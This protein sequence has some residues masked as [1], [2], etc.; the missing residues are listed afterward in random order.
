MR[1]VLDTNIIISG[2]FWHG[3]SNRVLESWVHKDF[4][5]VTS[6]ELL[7]ETRRILTGFKLRLP[8]SLIDI[9]IDVLRFY[10]DCVLPIIK[11]NLVL[12][13]SKD[14]IFVETAIAGMAEYIVSQDKHL[15]K[16]GEFA[17]IKMVSP[18][19]FL[20]CLKYPKAKGG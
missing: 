19:K 13:D 20:E 4:I 11:V 16:I 5:L 14:N 10:S 1:A 7:A 18:V 12:D 6:D 3:A 17:G 2:I 9:W 8:D 15:L